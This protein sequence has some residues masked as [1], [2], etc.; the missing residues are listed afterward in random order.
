MGI[1]QV[2]GRPV[3]TVYEIA[4]AFNV[5]RPTVDNWVFKAGNF[6]AVA[7]IVGQKQ[8]LYFADEVTG[9]HNVMIGRRNRITTLRSQIVTL[10]DAEF[11]KVLVLL[12]HK[13][14]VRPPVKSRVASKASSKK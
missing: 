9:W 10:S 5:S 7:H 11:A 8:K 3:W 4:K 2:D 6:P 14:S 1:L 13:A 12:D